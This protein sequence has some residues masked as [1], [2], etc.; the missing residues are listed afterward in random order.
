MRETKIVIVKKITTMNWAS[1]AP[2]KPGKPATIAD[3]PIAATPVNAVGITAPRSRE[4]STFS[5]VI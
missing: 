1:N 2:K 4:S 3:S 5:C